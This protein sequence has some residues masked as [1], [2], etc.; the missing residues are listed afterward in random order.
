ML[1]NLEHKLIHDEGRCACACGSVLTSPRE[2]NSLE[3]T[4]IMPPNKIYKIY[5]II[6]I[7]IL[8]I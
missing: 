1:N 7:D 8:K 3:C 2:E 4:I 6:F 5:Y